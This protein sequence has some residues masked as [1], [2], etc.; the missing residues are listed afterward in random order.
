MLGLS[1]A[2]QPLEETK[3]RI[4][5]Q[6]TLHVIV[7]NKFGYPNFLHMVIAS[8]QLLNIYLIPPGNDEGRTMQFAM[9]KEFVSPQFTI[10]LHNEEYHNK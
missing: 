10:L 6:F 9:K 7:E 8:W 1:D 2:A 3:S 4:S 5:G